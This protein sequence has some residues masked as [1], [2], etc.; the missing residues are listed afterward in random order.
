MTPKETII[1]IKV[2]VDENGQ[3]LEM[4]SDKNSITP[5]EMLGIFRYLEKITYE[6]IINSSKT[7][8]TK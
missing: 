7:P 1:Q 4:K 6:N 3:Q 2:I 5:F 8:E